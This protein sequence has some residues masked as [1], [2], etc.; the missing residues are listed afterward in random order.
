MT[1]VHDL[2]LY[3]YNQEPEF[4]NRSLCTGSMLTMARAP[5]LQANLAA[6]YVSEMKDLEKND[7]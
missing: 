1:A 3:I 6:E 2:V 7:M 5:A 4:V